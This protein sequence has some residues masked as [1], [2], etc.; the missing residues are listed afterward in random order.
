MV[1]Q[2]TKELIANSVDEFFAG[3]NH[4]VFVHADN[5]TGTYIVADKAEGIPVGMV[6]EDPSNPRSKKVS[7]MT[8]I[9]TEIHT[10][11]KFDDKAY[12]VSQGCFTGETKVSLLNGEDVSFKD[13]YAKFKKDRKPFYVYSFDVEEGSAF[14]PRLCTQV[15]KTMMTRNLCEVTLDTGRKIRCTP[16]HPFLTFEGDYV[17]AQNLDRG[18][19]LRAL[20]LG[21]DKDGYEIHSGRNPHKSTKEAK[22]HGLRTQRTVM[23]ELGFDIKGAHVHHRNGIKNDNRP[24]NLEV[25]FDRSEHF[26][27]DYSKNGKHKTFVHKNKK[28]RSISKLN[29][30]K[31]NSDLENGFNAQIGKIIQCAARALRDYGKLTESSYELCRGWC[32][33]SIRVVPLYFTKKELTALAKQYLHTYGSVGRVDNGGIGLNYKLQSEYSRSPVDNAANHFVSKV[34][35]IT[36]DDAVPVY[37]LTVEDKHN[38]LLAEGVFVHNTHGVGGSATNAVSASFEVWTNRDKKWHYQKFIK[39]KADKPVAQVRFPSDVKKILPYN[40]TCG[41][42]IRF[43]PDQTVV[44][45]DAG[46]TVAKLDLSFTAK[47][48]KDMAMLNPGIEL[49]MSA[50]GKTKS[51]LNRDGLVGILK[52]RVAELQLETTGRPFLHTSEAMSIALQLTSYAG[53]DGVNYYVNSGITRDGGEHEV[54]V[55]NTLA[56]VLKPFGKRND[57]Y[58]PKDLYFGMLG[59]VN[60]KMSGAAFSGQTKDRLTSNVAQLIDKELTPV[61]TAFFNKN[62]PLARAIIKRATEVKKSKDEF[63]KT[64]EAVTSAKRK[65]KNSLPVG[66]IQSPRCLPGVRELYIC[67]GDSAS[68]SA[69]KAR[70]PSFQ[71]V[72]PLTGKIANSARMPLH[73]LM[74]SK[75]VQ[76]ILT[77]IG[78]N[79][80]SHRKDNAEHKLRVNKL[81]LLPD[82]DVDGQH[83]TVLLLTLIH[84][85]M[86]SLFTEGRVHVVDAPLF[87]AYYKGNRYFGATLASVQKQLPRGAKCQIMRS[88]GWGEISHETLAI[89]AFNPTSR[90]T[91]QVKPV[92]GKELKHFEALVGNDALARKELLGL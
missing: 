7:T 79:F 26:W 88:K 6:A 15:H 67:E 90:T 52:S 41:T 12:S 53:D 87:S 13:L 9:F 60:Y 18:Q 46:K 50:N 72:L 70:D 54:G 58:A 43:K 4:Y 40:P 2:A 19:R 74:V 49:V 57:K 85:L 39:G 42:I 65:S 31:V 27:E 77:A 44:S 28:L 62:K 89:V 17:E 36:L 30:R 1:F 59:V 3:R 8:L 34:R 16:D 73:K 24:S 81:F 11:G 37:D 14:T 33:P 91:M 23:R 61:L 25:I 82:S 64:L 29:M 66:L 10:G 22:D 35:M 76:N 21:Y 92:V 71:E 55:R 63:K 75:A 83:I 32:Y 38:Y 5:A 68:G 86:P 80:D 47:W 51:Y 84:K 69:K 20:Y 48:L 45:V 56:K 78:Y